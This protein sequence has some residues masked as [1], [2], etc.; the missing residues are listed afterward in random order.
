LFVPIRLDD[1]STARKP[2][3]HVRVDPGRLIVANQVISAPALWVGCIEAVE[4]V[5]DLLTGMPANRGDDRIIDL[6]DTGR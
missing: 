2:P 5:F 1:P 4:G 3:H 6:G